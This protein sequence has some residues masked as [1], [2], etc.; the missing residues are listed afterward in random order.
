MSA[1]A[2]LPRHVFRKF[3][4]CSPGYTFSM[5]VEETTSD[6][7]LARQTAQEITESVNRTIDELIATG[8]Q[9]NSDPFVAAAARQVLKR[10]DW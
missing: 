2:G 6:K 8:E 9:I 7:A 3:R 4:S 10:T 1:P 5:E